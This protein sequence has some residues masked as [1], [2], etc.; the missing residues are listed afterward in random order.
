MLNLAKFIMFCRYCR[1]M[2]LLSE[3]FVSHLI[4]YARDVWQSNL[5]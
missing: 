4:C 1:R 2:L 3:A 5:V